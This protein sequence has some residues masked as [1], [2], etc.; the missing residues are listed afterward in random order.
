MVFERKKNS[1]ETVKIRLGVINSSK[2][3]S[4]ILLHPLVVGRV[5]VVCVTRAQDVRCRDL[6]IYIPYIHLKKKRS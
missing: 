5:E 2:K 3:V 4:V 1:R 6:F